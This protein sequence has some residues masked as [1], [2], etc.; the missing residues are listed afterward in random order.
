MFDRVTAP[1]IELYDGQTNEYLGRATFALTPEVERALLKMVNNLGEPDSTVLRDVYFFPASSSYVPPGMYDKERRNGIIRAEFR[2]ADSNLW[3]P[4][5]L[6]IRFDSQ[7]RGN[8]LGDRYHFRSVGYS[9]IVVQDIR[10]LPQGTSA[11]T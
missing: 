10:V 4:V 8:Y 3:M 5:D 11:H 6:Y 7:T 1:H 2:D 9:D